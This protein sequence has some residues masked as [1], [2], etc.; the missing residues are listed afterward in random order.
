MSIS[1]QCSMVVIRP[2][3]QVTIACPSD[4]QWCSSRS[5]ART[6]LTSIAILVLTLLGLRC[7]PDGTLDWRQVK[8][9]WTDAKERLGVRAHCNIAD[10]VFFHRDHVQYLVYLIAGRRCRRTSIA[11]FRYRR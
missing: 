9:I 4:W 7:R 6:D 2:L 1:G 8:S 10:C 3:I 11:R 5:H